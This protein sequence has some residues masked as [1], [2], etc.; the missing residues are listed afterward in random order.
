MS[1]GRRPA[2]SLLPSTAAEFSLKTGGH[3]LVRRAKRIP[4]S[5]LAKLSVAFAALSIATMLFILQPKIRVKWYFRPWIRPSQ[6]IVPS[7]KQTP[8]LPLHGCFANQNADSPYNRSVHTYYHTITSPVPLEDGL[9]CYDFAAMIK[10]PDWNDSSYP[11]RETIFHTYWRADLLPFGAKQLATIRSF[12][13]TQNPQHT[14]VYL[15]SNGDLSDNE[16]IKFIQQ[17][18]DPDRFQLRRFDAETF[19]VGTPIEG[20]PTLFH[21]NDEKAYLDGDLARLLLLYHYG[22]LWFDMDSML[23]RDMTPLVERE[24]VLQW[25]CFMPYE[26][27][28]NGAYMHFFKQSPYLCEMLADIAENPIPQKNTISWGSYLYLKTRRK[29]LHNRIQPFEV[30]PWC[31]TDPSVCSPENSMPSIFDVGLPQGAHQEWQERLKSVF[32]FHWHNQ[33]DKTPGD[34]YYFLKDQVD[35]QLDW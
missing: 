10:A 2:Y 13:A 1:M 7:S 17:H 32:A 26:Y 19:S 31:L 24:W 5:L 15:W 11:F 22:G 21:T 27:P 18:V 23:I 29:L 28:Y 8:V 35:A 33:W 12:F 4:L 30:L 16:N 3:Q 20:H 14:K 34:V 9:D 6:T 25:D